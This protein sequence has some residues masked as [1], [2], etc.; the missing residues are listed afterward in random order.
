V[1]YDEKYLGPLHFVGN[2]ISRGSY[3]MVRSKQLRERQQIFS[4]RSF[5][6]GRAISCARKEQRESEMDGSRGS[7]VRREISW[8]APLSSVAQF[9]EARM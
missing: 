7:G 6:V 2:A 5:F 1:A 4:D 9:H 8:A 3:V